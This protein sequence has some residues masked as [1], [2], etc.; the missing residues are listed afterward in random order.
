VEKGGVTGGIY[1]I[2]EAARLTGISETRIRRWLM[3]YT[4]KAGG[5]TRKAQPV[6]SGELAPIRGRH[7]ASFRDLIEMRFV[8]A[9]VDL[10]VNWKHIREAQQQA[11]KTLG[12]SHPFSTNRFQTDGGQIF[13]EM[14]EQAGR[15]R[16]V[17]VTSGQELLIGLTAPFLD[18]LELDGSETVI[19]WWPLGKNR[20]VALDPAVRMGRSCL[21]PAGIPT[22]VIAGLCRH[23]AEA[24]VADWYG[25][26]PDAVRDAVAWELDRS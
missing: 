13:V 25:L 5:G 24:R 10:G 15:T 6:W 20:A 17:D 19:R 3:G 14:L 9:F 1:A 23:E 4:Y 12:L 16:L 18:E 8:Q 26:T 2:P 11:R 22:G 7:A 21:F